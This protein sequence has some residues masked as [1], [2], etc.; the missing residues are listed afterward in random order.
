MA[1][2]SSGS[3]SIS[4]IKSEV[5]GSSSSLRSLSNAAGKSAP[6]GMQEFYGYSHVT[7]TSFSASINSN[8]GAVCSE[9]IVTTYYHD[10][11][12]TYPDVGDTVY[13]NSSGSSYLSSG[14]Y[15]LGSGDY[16]IVS[17]SG[18]VTSVDPCGFP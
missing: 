4:Q 7:L 18:S 11:S 13:S 12:F 16:M 1:L 9:S 5:G 6:D 8:F 10:G 2:Q 3:I 14:Y 17:S 15:K